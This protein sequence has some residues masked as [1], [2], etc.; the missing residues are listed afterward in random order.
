L[1]SNITAHRAQGQ[2]MADCL[3]SVDL[4][5]ENPDMKMPLEISSFLYV[6][7]TR[8]TKLSNLFVSQIHPCLRQ[9]IGQTD[10]DKH[11]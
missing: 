1:A 7:C 4:G 11:R 2:T 10:T 3:V 8:V 5:L 6:A 9:K